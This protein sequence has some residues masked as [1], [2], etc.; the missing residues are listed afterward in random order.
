[1]RSGIK[2]DSFT[3][4]QDEYHFNSKFINKTYFQNRPIYEITP[5]EYREFIELYKDM[6]NTS[7]PLVRGLPEY[8]DDK[9]E[10][11]EDEVIEIHSK[12]IL[13][14]SMELLQITPSIGSGVLNV[15]TKAI[16]VEKNKLEEIS[17]TE[18]RE[19][20]I[21]YYKEL[22]DKARELFSQED[23]E[24]S[25]NAL[26][27]FEEFQN[28]LIEQEKDIVADIYSVN[29]ENLSAKLETMLVNEGIRFGEV[30]AASFLFNQEQNNKIEKE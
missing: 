13:D 21:E 14:S 11:I 18:D 2:G 3:E 20:M 26:N 1:M 29:D 15:L 23:T 10:Q 12:E 5:E 17:E 25:Q 8:I 22:C 4:L 30:S 28:E 19:K 16:E 24:K 7:N 27:V 6:H 9:F